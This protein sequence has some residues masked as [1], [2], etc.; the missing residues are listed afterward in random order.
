[1]WDGLVGFL[2][3]LLRPVIETLP[4]GAP[5]PIPDLSGV[6]RTLGAIDQLVPIAGPL[7]AALGLLAALGV[8]I[9]VRLVLLVWNLIYP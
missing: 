1:M 6:G 8:F 9:A 3:G 5:L 4:A 2:T 7:S